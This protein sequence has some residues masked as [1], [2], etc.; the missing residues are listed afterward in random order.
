[1]EYLIKDNKNDKIVSSA[2]SIGELSD[3][4]HTFNE[5]YDFRRV[6]KAARGHS[7][8]WTSVGS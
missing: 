3:G 1:M 4:Y 6:Y 2:A 7:G 8:V 5:L